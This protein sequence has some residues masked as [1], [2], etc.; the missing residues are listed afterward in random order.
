MEYSY[1][2]R[3][4]VATITP[5][6][7][8][9][10]LAELSDRNIDL[11]KDEPWSNAREIITSTQR[12]RLTF[13]QS[14]TLI[15]RAI[16]L[17]NDPDLGLHVGGRQSFA[18]FGL[19]SAAML[20]SSTLREALELGCRYHRVSGSMLEVDL[21]AIDDA[22]DALSIRSRFAGSPIRRFLMQEALIVI[23][24]S[25]RFL[26]SSPD[27]IV[28]VQTPFQPVDPKSFEAMCPCPVVY[29]GD[30]QYVVFRKERL[31]ERLETSDPFALSETA[32]I[33]EMLLKTELE[34]VD[35]LQTVEG[36]ILRNFPKVETLAEMS[37]AL[38]S[39]ERS[40]RR[41]LANLGTSYRE[42]LSRLRLDRARQRIEEGVLSRDQIAA[43]LGFSDARS[44]RRLLQG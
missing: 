12:Q 24:K 35:F 2:K 25:A 40:V 34:E 23:L 7:L 19:V 28:E 39:S 20:A 26:S 1:D 31:A 27:T 32:T 5:L 38:G 22:N 33:L 13:R 30:R 15:Q 11:A 43:D 44:L 4:E 37:T 10:T 36:R 6:I 8:Y 16:S 18:S 29:G 3:L 41:Q 21:E 9:H 17:T 14:Q 42:L